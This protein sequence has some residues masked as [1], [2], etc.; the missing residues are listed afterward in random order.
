[1]FEEL[2][3]QA[4]FRPSDAMRR[5]VIREGRRRRRRAFLARAGTAV[6]ATLAVSAGVVVTAFNRQI[7]SIERVE[8]AGLVGPEG[9]SAPYT[10]LLTGFDGDLDSGGGVDP[11]RSD[12]IGL[13]RVQPLT[14]SV[15]F[16]TV[17]RDLWVDIPGRGE[18]RINGAVVDGTGKLIEALR[19]NF[20]IEVNHYVG[21]DLTGAVALGDA[22]GGLR[23]DFEHPT[24]DRSTGLHVTAL[25]C[26]VLDGRQVLALARSRRLEVETAPGTWAADLTSDFGRMARQQQMA[27]AGLATFSRL[28]P[29]DPARLDAFI[30]AVVDHVV[31]DPMTDRDRMVQIFRDVAG[32]R[33]QPA[34]LPVEPWTSPNG[35]VALVP[36]SDGS[37]QVAL[38][39]FLAG[40]GAGDEGS[41][42]EEGLGGVDV[43]AETDGLVGAVIPEAC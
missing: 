31:L 7:D 26:Q 41:S 33:L 38:D 25:G 20:G 27:L 15:T 12:S 1:M 37:F 9:D 6:V 29:T 14:D 34:W 39:R 22:V 5:D 36:A 32:S 10:I 18:G 21:L 11:L 3:D 4:P 42:A 8:V 23:F 35:T 28:D 19:A 17:P 30:D 2:D 40:S 24:R 13:V 43:T 16:L